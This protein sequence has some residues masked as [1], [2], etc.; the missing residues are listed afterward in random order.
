MAAHAYTPT[1]AA[2]TAVLDTVLETAQVQQFID[3][4][5]LWVTEEL[6]PDSGLSTARL[7]LITRYLA[8]ALVRV[9]D[10]GLKATTIHDTQEAYQVDPQVTDYLLR[11]AGFDSTGTVRLQFLG[12][13]DGAP[14][15]RKI[16]ARVGAG[17]SAD[18]A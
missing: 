2:V 14:S 13:A 10:L 17:R 16:I 1:V 3:D 11:A 18:D 8:A 15:V 7:E 5:D 4:A 12:A 6:V 9:R